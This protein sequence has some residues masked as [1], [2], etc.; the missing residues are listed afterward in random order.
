MKKILIA[1]LIISLLVLRFSFILKAPLYLDEGIY[2][3]WANLTHQSKDFAYNS[4]QDGK[5]PLYFWTISILGPILNN[6]LLSGRLISIFAGLVTAICWMIIFYK[7]F[8]IRKSFIYLILYLVTPFGFLVERMA[9][10]DSLLVALASLSLMFLMLSKNLLENKYRRWKMKLI[11]YMVFSGISLGLAYATKTTARLFFVTYLIIAT[12]W[13]L[14]YIRYKNFKNVILILFGLILF[15]L[16]YNEII[17]FFRV[18]GHIFWN[19]IAE[20][21][22][23]MI[24]SPQEIFKR[25]SGNPLSVFNYFGLLLQYW[26]YYLS[27]LMLFVVVGSVRLISI[28]ENHKF[29]WL[30]FYWI[31]VTLAICLSGRVMASRYIYATYPV[32]IAIAVFGVDFLMSFKNRIINNIVY[33]LVFLVLGQ[34]CLLV[35]IPEKALYAKDD[36]NYFVSSELTALGIPDVIKYFDDKDKSSVLIGISGTWG[37]PEGSSILF[38]EAGLKSEIININRII[39]NKPPVNNK[40]ENNWISKDDLCWNLDFITKDESGIIKYLYVVGDD[41][42]VSK[43]IELGAKKIIQFDRYRGST[44]T[45]LLQMPILLTN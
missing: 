44:K 25:I 5:T 18:G 20:K 2:I 26:G 14:N 35:F 39:L 22:K 16:F 40:C 37:V 45:Y 41:K 28:K 38:K 29:I 19:S 12:F 23:L 13:L 7:N 10:S 11:L 24:Y 33:I 31:F 27:A 32:M 1:A 43:I 30:L 17:N 9:L 8:N 42:L 4:L 15:V 21:E 36:Q 6:F 34:S 3:S